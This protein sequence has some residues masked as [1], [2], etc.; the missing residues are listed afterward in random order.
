M[1]NRYFYSLS[2][3]L[4][5]KAHRSARHGPVRTSIVCAQYP[6]PRRAD[7]FSLWASWVSITHL[8]LR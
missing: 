7:P 8:H 5:Y 3:I 4:V 1:L 6:D 2:S